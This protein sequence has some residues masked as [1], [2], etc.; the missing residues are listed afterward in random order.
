[1]FSIIAGKTALSTDFAELYAGP[2]WP[3]GTVA[4]A[5]QLLR[6]SMR[7]LKQLQ[8]PWISIG[9]LRIYLGAYEYLKKFQ[10]DEFLRRY[11][12]AGSRFLRLMLYLIL[13]DKQAKDW[14]DGTRIGYDKTFSASVAGFE[15]Q[16]H[17]VYPR[18]A[19]KKA[20]VSDDKI[21]ALSNI[22][23]L[24]ERTHVRKLASKEPAKYIRQFEIPESALRDHLVPDT[25]AAAVNEQ[26]D[27]E[28]QW[29]LDRYTDFL[30]ERAQLLAKEAN[31]FLEKLE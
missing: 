25:F 19:L 30:L 15:P 18:S 2:F 1:M 22:T 27:L 13:F 7:T 26:A 6:A 8:R 29:G 4:T 12:Q 24:N 9:R 31:A 16:W 17:H 11:D 28:R 14:V 3:T 23:V 5:D 20:N 21:H 10:E